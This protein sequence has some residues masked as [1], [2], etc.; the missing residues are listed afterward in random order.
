MGK[1][2]PLGFFLKNCNNGTEILSFN[3]IETILG[4]P[5]PNS[6]TTRREWW[7][8]END[9]TTR[10]THCK[11]WLRSGWKVENVSLGF[12]VTFKKI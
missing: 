4:F 1:Y 5:L 3:E 12:N 10:H 11:E 7:G 6:A 9:Q 2:A 8:N